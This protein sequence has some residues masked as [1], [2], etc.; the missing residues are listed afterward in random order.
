LA[1]DVSLTLLGQLEVLI[2]EHDLLARDAERLEE[3]VGGGLADEVCFLALE[4]LSGL[5]FKVGRVLVFHFVDVEDQGA[6]FEVLAQGTL[7]CTGKALID[8]S[9]SRKIFFRGHF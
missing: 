9:A 3:E 7:L 5:Q 8:L 2:L 1:Y 4:Q 6:L